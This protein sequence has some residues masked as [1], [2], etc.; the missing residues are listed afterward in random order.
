[1]IYKIIPLFFLALVI[2]GCQKNQT[3]EIKDNNPTKSPDV[4]TS[5]RDYL[6]TIRNSGFSNSS[7]KSI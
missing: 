1:M 6:G 7:G 4:F 5:I 3:T 2:S